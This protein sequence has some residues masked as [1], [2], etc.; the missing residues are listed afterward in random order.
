MMTLDEM[1]DLA[2]SSTGFS[3]FG[4]PVFLEPLSILIKSYNEEAQLSPIGS[5][6]IRGE[7]LT[8]LSARLRVVEGLKKALGASTKN[9]DKPIFILG[10][11]RTGTT[12][13]HNMIQANPD[14][15]VLEHWLGISPRPRPLRVEWKDDP[16][17]Q[18]IDE[19]LRKLYEANPEYRVQHDVS[20][21]GADECRLILAHSFMD[22]T[23]GYLA[24]LPG[25]RKWLDAQCM[26]PAYRW[27]KSVLQLLQYPDDTNR[28]WVL[29]Y[30][31]HLAWLKDLF[32]VYPDACVIHTHRDPVATVPSFASLLSGVASIFSDKWSPEKI[33]PFLARQWSQRMD[34]YLNLREQLNRENQFFDIQFADVLEDPVGILER[35]FEKFDLELSDK[36]RIAMS[37]WHG[38]NPRGRH[39]EHQYTP[40]QFG[41]NKRVLA[42]SFERY[43]RR[44]GIND[45]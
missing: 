7:L 39:G 36:A 1:L 45:E 19:N 26:V 23:F 18:R 17:Y 34:N 44:F 20:V 31:S 27:H 15:Q 14:C 30:P 37:D 38:K 3:D 32:E 42:Q 10:L 11:P 40:E 25:Y 13:L 6:A 2:T 43:R 8:I 22:D 16:D 28:R 5:Q 4:C 41:L 33:G 9:I 12:T 24:D 29:K 35:A 21:D